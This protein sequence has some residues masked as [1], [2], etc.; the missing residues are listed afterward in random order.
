[1]AGWPEAT[2]MAPLR[3]DLDGIGSAVRSFG[4]ASASGPKPGRSVK[5]DVRRGITRNV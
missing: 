2:G 3:T 4:C 5:S 1:M